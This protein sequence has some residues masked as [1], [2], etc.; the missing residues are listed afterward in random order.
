MVE[1]QQVGKKKTYFN[2]FRIMTL[3]N[4]TWTDGNYRGK[5]RPN[6]RQQCQVPRVIQHE[7][8]VSM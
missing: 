6:S 8:L 1:F 3:R 4:S 7:V 5:L 2:L